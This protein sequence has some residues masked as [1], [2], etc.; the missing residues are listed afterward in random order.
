MN[1]NELVFVSATWDTTCTAPAGKYPCPPSHVAGD[2]YYYIFKMSGSNNSNI[3]KDINTCTPK[4][5]LAS[6]PD[7]AKT[8]IS[9]LAHYNSHGKNEKDLK[10]GKPMCN[11][12]EK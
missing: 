12:I 1:N 6:R 7:V 11:P 10:T 9:A 4:E 2:A 8:G 3:I 5:Y